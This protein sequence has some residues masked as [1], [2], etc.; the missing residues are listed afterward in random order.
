MRQIFAAALGALVLAA[1]M[2]AAAAGWRYAYE[3]GAATAT[4]TNDD[5][6]VIVTISCRPPDGE[7]VLTD[8]T[9]GREVR[10]ATQATVT[11]GDMSVTVPATVTRERRK[12]IVAIRLPQRP[13][14]LAGIQ[15]HHTLSVTVAGQTHT[16]S[17]GGPGK[18]A[19]VAYGCWQS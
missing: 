8:Y 19:E 6:D 10:R 9:F 3:N 7:M 11:I 4:E 12:H 13:P 15:P 5:N 16:Y 18:M 14:V 2:P 17:S 1:A